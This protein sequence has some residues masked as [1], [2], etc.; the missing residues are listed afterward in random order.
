MKRKIQRQSL[1][2]LRNCEMNNFLAILEFC[3]FYIKYKNP[4][5]TRI[6]FRGRTNVKYFME[7]K[8]LQFSKDTA[9]FPC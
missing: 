8:L 1:I 9:F 2:C 3:A 4:K 7:K 5:F 6:N